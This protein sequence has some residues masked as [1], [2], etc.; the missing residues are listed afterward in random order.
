MNKKILITVA[1]LIVA[2]FALCSCKATSLLDAYDTVKNAKTVVQTITVTNGTAEVAKQTSTFDMASG[3]ANVEKKVLNDVSADEKYTTTT[4]T[5]DFTK[6]EAVANLK[7]LTMT[8]VVETETSFKGSVANAD[9]KT[10]FGIEVT[11]V[12][13]DATVELTVKDGNVTE[14]KVTYTSSNDNAVVITTT[15]AY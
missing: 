5:K 4:E 6:S 2:L 9:I 10:A 8:A 13:G 11:S 15:F 14:M 1:V 7:G 12:K 3:K